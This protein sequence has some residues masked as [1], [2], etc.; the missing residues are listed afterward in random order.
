MIFNL[1]SKHY[2]IFK[3][4]LQLTKSMATRGAVVDSEADSTPRDQL[5]V[6]PVK[7]L[8]GLQA[9]KIVSQEPEAT[10]LLALLFFMERVCTLLDPGSSQRVSIT[11]HSYVDC[12]VGKLLM[13]IQSRGR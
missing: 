2:S 3:V 7:R 5:V 4:V 10:K 13:S 9:W 1:V 12:D 6:Q 11:L 8:Y